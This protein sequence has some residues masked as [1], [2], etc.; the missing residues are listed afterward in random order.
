MKR[1]NSPLIF[2]ILFGVFSVLASYSLGKYVTDQDYAPQKPQKQAKQYFEHK[3]DRDLA[4]AYGL[5][6]EDA[7][8][9]INLWGNK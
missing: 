6:P 5:T 4:E 3:L 7:K 8:Q 1:I 9:P 2:M